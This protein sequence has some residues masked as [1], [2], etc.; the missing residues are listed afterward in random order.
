MVHLTESSLIFHASYGQVFHASYGQDGVPSPILANNIVPLSFESLASIV[1][2]NISDYLV[3]GVCD[4]SL[5]GQSIRISVRNSE[6]NPEEIAFQ[7]VSCDA[8]P[9]G[10]NTFAESFDLSAVRD[11][12]GS[13][14]TFY[15]S[16]GGQSVESPPVA[17]EVI[18]LGF[19]SLS[20][21]NLSNAEDYEVSGRCDASVVT[22]VTVSL[23]N[24]PGVPSKTSLCS[25]TGNTFSLSFDLRT[26][27]ASE[28]IFELSHGSESSESSAVANNIVN[29]AL[30][31][32]TLV[33]ITSDNAPLYT[34]SGFCDSSLTPEKV[35]V[36]VGTPDVMQ[37]ADCLSNSSFSVS[38]D[39]SEVVANPATVLVTYGTQE[40][41]AT[42]INELI[43]LGLA[44][45]PPRL[46]GA[47]QSAYTL[48]GTCNSAVSGQVTLAV[49]ETNASGSAACT[50]N[51][52]S[53]SVDASNTNT[54]PV[55]MT[56]SH[57]SRTV[58]VSVPSD[59]VL[60]SINAPTTP[61][62]LA[63]AASYTL[64]GNCDPN[65]SGQVEVTLVDTNSSSNN[66]I[67]TSDC[68]AGAAGTY[69]VTLNGQ[70]LMSDPVLIQATHGTYRA[71]TQ[72][73][74]S[75]VRLALAP[76]PSDFNLATALAYSIS[77]ACDFSLAGGQ[78]VT[79]SLEGGGGSLPSGIVSCISD[80]TFAVIFDASAI[81]ESS[82]TV[83]AIYGTETQ[84]SASV[85]NAI[86][87]L[88][89]TQPTEPLNASTAEHYSIA[90][91]CDA[92]LSGSAYVV[93]AVQG[94]S[95]EQTVSCQKF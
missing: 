3:E 56:L 48:V 15:A 92:S 60:L 2:G 9:E 65:V 14:V 90:G 17:N 45:A 34:L 32:S 25:T 1:A 44:G 19:G 57:G 16:Y 46:T 71:N 39:V 53:V 55:P 11:V 6:E 31:P 41:T 43:H 38:M 86:V 42:V 61:F 77:G 72:V 27:S 75:I 95:V 12:L 70:G 87:R 40:Q 10:L 7:E 52:F 28:V 81:T 51:A 78:T 36:T 91:H 73:V 50:N 79:V 22:P 69:S 29:L 64:T 47:N 4:S 80:N 62:N 63:N 84:T 24:L 18:P 35:Q 5:S 82:F 68:T 83:Q 66:V 21:L 37:S 54:A 8:T 74:N 30:D 13:S 26:L 67:E 76:L 94:T 89:I 20:P 88:S 33:S 23:K 85:P 93:V 59:I 49:T 58:N